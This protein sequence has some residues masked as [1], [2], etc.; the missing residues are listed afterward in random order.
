MI[1]FPVF[2]IK[3]AILHT[4]S[5]APPSI[6]AFFKPENGEKY[7]LLEEGFILSTEMIAFANA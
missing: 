5:R 1:S 2:Y 7:L 4:D 6:G 3:H